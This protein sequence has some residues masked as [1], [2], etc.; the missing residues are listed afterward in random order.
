MIFM[1]GTFEDYD[2]LGELDGSGS[3]WNWGGL[4][5]YFKKVS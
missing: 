5:P 3:D 1:R 4:L 2:R